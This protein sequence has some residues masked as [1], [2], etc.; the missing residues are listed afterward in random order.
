MKNHGAEHLRLV[1]GLINAGKNRGNWSAP[2][3]SAVSWLVLNKPEL[4]ERRDF[5]EMFDCLDL[6]ILLK[7]SKAVNPAAPTVTMRI[8]LSAEVLSQIEQIE[9]AKVA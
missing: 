7:R 6:E 8:L 2:C 3:M 1:F 9:I 4:I 5:I